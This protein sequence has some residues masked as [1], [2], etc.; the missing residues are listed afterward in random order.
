MS[1]N[2]LTIKSTKKL[3]ELRRRKV[4]S[5]EQTK[6]LIATIVILQ[7]TL[8]CVF[9]M[10]TLMIPAEAAEHLHFAVIVLQGKTPYKDVV[11]MVSP[12]MLYLDVIPAYISK[13]VHIHPI[14]VF[15]LSVWTLSCISQYLCLAILFKSQTREKFFFSMVVLAN[16]LMQFVFIKEF[17]Q[18]DHLFLLF[19]IPYWMTRLMRWNGQKP[20]ESLS[21]FAGALAG[22]GFSLNFLYSIFFILMELCFW[23]ENR[24]QDAFTGAEFP[25]CCAIIILYVGHMIVLPEAIASGYI[26]WILPLTLIDYWQWDNRL[27]YVEKTPDRRDLIY[28]FA[29]VSVLAMGFG[30]RSKILIPAI[31]FSVLGFGLYI[32]QGQMFTY[33][34]L[35]M[36]WG[37]G[38]AISILIA[39]V[40]TLLPDLSK[41][42]NVK[43]VA[44]ILLTASA[45]Y[46][47][48]QYIP[49]SK[50]EKF[51]L[52]PQKY[53]GSAPKCDLSNFSEFFEANCNAGDEVLI[54]ND[55]TRPAYPLILQMGLKP[56]GKLL[57][58]APSRIYE[59]YFALN[60]DMAIKKFI[61]PE[62]QIWEEL[63]SKLSA[64][65]PKVVMYDEEAMNSLLTKHSLKT[66]LTEI[67]QE[68]LFVDW[69][70]NI[71]KHPKF[72]Y[73]SFRFPIA[74]HVKKK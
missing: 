55:R 47:Y 11:D 33:Q 29:I 2:T 72:E 34:S 26:S 63:P 54:F 14:F 74:A 41:L 50:S 24:K 48:F 65:P 32:A 42:M 71:D 27:A 59:N 73:L 64:N 16:C 52:A 66:K 38:F 31:I 70:E 23:L 61:Y 36:I 39:I 56:A 67:Y 46:L 57:D 51:D 6:A 21:L 1:L 19:T 44:P 53:F 17:G 20:A 62:N 13:L 28:L 12:M 30:R 69:N 68:P 58:Y 43:I 4:L 8:L 22:I 3:T 25:C 37:V 9:C 7:L 45:V 49:V 5:A 15:N 60:Q 10:H 40:L 18:I 35:P